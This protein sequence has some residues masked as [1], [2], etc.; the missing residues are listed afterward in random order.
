[1]VGKEVAKSKRRKGCEN[2]RCSLVM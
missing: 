2:W 1:M